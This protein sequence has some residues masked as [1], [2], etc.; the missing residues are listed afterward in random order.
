MRIINLDVGICPPS[1][2]PN[3]SEQRHSAGQIFVGSV[4]H[5][6]ELKNTSVSKSDHNYVD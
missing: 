4:M 6:A 1:A 3:T 2:A 5:V